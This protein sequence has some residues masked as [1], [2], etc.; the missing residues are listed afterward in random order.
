MDEIIVK[1]LLNTDFSKS[2]HEI[3]EYLEKNNYNHVIYTIKS[4]KISFTDFGTIKKRRRN[5]L[6]YLLRNVIASNKKYESLD[7]QFFVNLDDWGT[8]DIVQD[9]PILMYSKRDGSKN[10]SIPDY[11]FLHN[12]ETYGGRNSNKISANKLIKQLNDTVSFDD[13][14]DK[15]FFRAGT[16]KNKA[17]IYMFNPEKDKH[18]DIN[19]SRNDFMSYENMFKHKFVISHYMKW[20]SIYFFLKS[21]ILM[22][23]YM[24]F[25]F[26]LWY[27]LFLENNVDYITFETRDEFNQKYN[28]LINDKERCKKIIKHSTEIS[29][30]WFTYEK[31]TEYMGELLLEIQKR[32][33]TQKTK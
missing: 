13:K 33:K 14:M 15:C 4:G 6:T 25:N 11:L 24:G 32:Q 3:K 22:F 17:I 9:L 16:H 19:W 8:N 30:K 21:D 7:I 20:D 23:N 1:A 10:I 5:A 27:D 26:R 2:N 28:E 12:Y 18:M 31:A 29:D